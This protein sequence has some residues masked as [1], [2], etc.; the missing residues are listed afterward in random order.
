MGFFT[1]YSNPGTHLIPVGLKAY[2]AKEHELVGWYVYRGMINTNLLE[3]AF[4]PEL[5]GK[6]IGKAQIHELGGYYQW[7]PS[8]SFDIRLAGNLAFLGSGFKDIARAWPT[9]TSRRLACRP[10]TATTSR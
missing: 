4:A 8:L 1:T 9:A 10:V 5:A 6:G 2:P 7:T 3:V